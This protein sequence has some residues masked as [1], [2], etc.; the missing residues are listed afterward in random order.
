MED[1]IVPSAAHLPLSLDSLEGID[2]ILEKLSPS[3]AAPL[4]VSNPTVPIWSAAPDSNPLAREGSEGDFTTDADV[5][6]IGSGISGISAAYHLSNL[7]R[8]EKTSLK[9]VVLEGRDFCSGATGRNGGHLTPS[10]FNSFGHYV[11]MHGVNGAR[12]TV[13]LE[14]QTV[15]DIIDLVDEGGWASDIELVEG[16]HTKLLFTKNELGCMRSDWKAAEAAGIDL[17]ATQWLTN[18]EMDAKYGTPFPGIH[19]PGYNLWPLKLVTKLYQHAG[20][21]STP[22]RFLPAFFTRPGPFSLTLHT[23]TPVTSVT[24]I[25]DAPEGRRWRLSTPRGDITTSYVLH[26]T[27]AYAS[28]LLPQ[29]IGKIMPTRGQVIATRSSV[30]ISDFK[31]TSSAW[32]AN[33]GFEY[34]FPKLTKSADEHPL[35]VIGGGRESAAPG[36]EFNVADDSTVNDKVG[37]T[38]RS[39]LPCVF[40]GQFETGQEPELEWTG[41]MGFT[42]SMDPFVGPVPPVGDEKYAGAYICAGFSGHGM[43]RAF[44]CAQAVAEMIV[45]DMRGEKWETPSWMPEWYLTTPSAS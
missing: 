33:E 3:S 17:S 15:K 4:P 16:G 8:Q 42:K 25:P 22:S 40:P 12:R 7:A 1:I 36:F 37:H 41:I 20:R 2:R 19:M 38:L 34:F 44:K 21:A 27:N 32:W 43:T 13:E 30:P 14:N 18:K 10:L 45:A 6:I 24:A 9:V 39:F 35:V 5:C 26:A 31:L 23:H 11:Q 28:H 29:M